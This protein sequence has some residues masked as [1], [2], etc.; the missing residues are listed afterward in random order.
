MVSSRTPSTCLSTW[1]YATEPWYD[2]KDPIESARPYLEKH[3]A[4]ESIKHLEMRE[5]KG[6]RTF[7]FTIDDFVQEWPQF[8]LCLDA[9][10]PFRHKIVHNECESSSTF[11]FTHFKELNAL[12]GPVLLKVKSGRFNG[13]LVVTPWLTCNTSPSATDGNL[14]INYTVTFG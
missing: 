14:A 1:F 13:I 10:G 7:A 5:I 12:F 6:A 8:F 2:N 11:Y 4:E 9:L 3:G